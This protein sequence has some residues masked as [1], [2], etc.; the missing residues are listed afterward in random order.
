MVWMMDEEIVSFRFNFLFD[1]LVV[2]KG[3]NRCG[4]ILLVMFVLE[5]WMCSIVCWCFVLIFRIM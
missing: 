2:K 3:L 4:I 1:D 5:L